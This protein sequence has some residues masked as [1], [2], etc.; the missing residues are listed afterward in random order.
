MFGESREKAN[1]RKTKTEIINE[2]FAEIST[3][4][5][6]SINKAAS[7]TAAGVLVGEAQI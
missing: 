1:R 7:D 5:A 2:Y 6:L 3:G 4:K